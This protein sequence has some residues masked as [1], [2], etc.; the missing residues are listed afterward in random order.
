MFKILSTQ[1][2]WYHYAILCTLALLLRAGTFYFYIQHEERYH[3]ADSNDYHVAALCITHNY[4]MTYPNGR[5]IFWRTPGYPYYLSK[6]YNP[7]QTPNSDFKYFTQTHQK[8]LWTQ[9]ILCSL[10]PL[11]I[12]QLA[13]T[14]TASLPIS[15][16]VALISVFHIGFVLA[17]T[18]LLTDA[19]AMLFFMMFLIFFYPVYVYPGLQA[20]QT[21]PGKYYNIYL[22]L[23]L[24]ALSLSIF[25][26]MRPNGQFI[27]IIAI[28]LLLFSHGTWLAN[29]K[30]SLLFFIIF[31]IT[32]FPW[33]YRN[34]QLTNQWFFCPL[35]GLYLN[36]FN[37]PKILARTENI[38]LAEAHKKLSQAAGL[39]TT[40]ELQ[41][42]KA[43]SSAK[44]VCPE[45]ICIK[46]A[47]P[48]I[49]AHPFYFIYDWFTEATKTAFD[50][51]S[52]Q[53][54]ALAHNCFKWDPMVEYLP[55]K[56]HACLYTKPLPPFMRI[57]AWLELLL[58]IT[59]WLGIF[60]GLFKFVIQ[61]LF[62][63]QYEL[64]SAYGILWLT[65]GIFIGATMLQTGG[66]GYARLRLPIE[67]L[68]LILGITF[69]WWVFNRNKKT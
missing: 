3:Q 37:A 28:V 52:C 16:L 20:R 2:R 7:T 18:F 51:Y 44:T 13:L 58:S 56:L 69:W 30:K 63:R 31:F 57:I 62:T 25:T 50:L 41:K 66:F 40:Q 49:A 8:A 26:W 11:L 59:I 14:L 33:F 36:A 19:L 60:A 43:Q 53:L 1:P 47:W 45:N 42:V 27:G 29:L 68:M 12:F 35:F 34:H 21:T 67:P 10:L 6:F 9:L 24:A 61:P 15:W 65:A 5:P 38:P 22:T 4:G 39:L 54:T 48:V 55:E 32:L 46:T 17:S 64:F 23:A